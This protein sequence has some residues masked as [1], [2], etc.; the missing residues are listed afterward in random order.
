MTTDLVA[1][2]PSLNLLGELEQ[3]GVA[4]TETSLDLQAVVDFKSYERLCEFL[5]SLGRSYCWWVGD[6]IN[7][8]ERL[9]GEDAVQAIDSLGLHPGTCIN[10]AYTCQKIA[11]NRRRPDLSFAHHR[12]V[13]ALPPDAQTAWLEKAAVSRWTRAQL[14]EALEEERALSE[15]VLDSVVEPPD[16]LELAAAEDALVLK[17]KAMA[18]VRALVAFDGE[19]GHS[20]RCWIRKD[21]KEW[22]DCACGLERL[23]AAVAALGVEW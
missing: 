2:E 14:S 21:G 8:G 9:F 22:I 20:Y 17:E 13:T 4:L 3:A 10:Y 18:V 12:V 15:P 16:P 1:R 11:R 7:W 6:L 19:L 23:E 5:G